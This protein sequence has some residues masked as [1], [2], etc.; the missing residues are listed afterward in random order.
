M[1]LIS[2]TTA[3]GISPAFTFIP[4]RAADAGGRNPGVL[5]YIDGIGMRPAMHRLAQR[6]ADL[7]YLVLMPDVFYR[8]GAYEAPDMREMFKDPQVGK[9]W[10]GK[11]F[12]AAAPALVMRDT[13]SYLDALASDPRVMPVKVGVTGYCMGGRLA[14]IA[15]ATM[16]DRIAAAG[17]FHPGGLVTEEP[18]SPH[19]LAPAIRGRVYVAGAI[20]DSNFTDAQ[21]GRLDDALTAAGVSHTVA[22]YPAKH[23]WVPDDS[24]VHD[25][26]QAERHFEALRELFAATLG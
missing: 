17:A 2:I 24:P 25:A 4:S 20:E 9:A 14:V 3:D 21:R 11:V 10:F 8:L 7:G 1:S 6:V 22:V 12:P 5:L 23:G 26:A 18:S 15:A 13:A 16:P 19:L